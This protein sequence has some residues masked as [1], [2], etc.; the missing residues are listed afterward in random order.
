M[1]VAAKMRSRQMGTVM[2]KGAM[3]SELSTL[4]QE[5]LAMPA[6]QIAIQLL[7]I[8]IEIPLLYPSLFIIRCLLFKVYDMPIT[9]FF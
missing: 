4:L 2:D 5:V 3:M 9:S 8:L 1:F 7:V 6:I